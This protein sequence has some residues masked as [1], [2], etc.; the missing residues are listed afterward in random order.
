MFIKFSQLSIMSEASRLSNAST[1]GLS[2]ILICF[3][4]LF[5]GTWTTI[6]AKTVVSMSGTNGTIVEDKDGTHHQS[7][8]L[9]KEPMLLTFV[10]F[11][12]MAFCLVVHVLLEFVKILHTGYNFGTHAGLLEETMSLVSGDG[13]TYIIPE[14]IIIYTSKIPLSTYLTIAIP[15]MLDLGGTLLSFI[16][17]CY[18][19][20]SVSRMLMG[21]GIVFT[22]LMRQHVMKESLHNFQWVGVFWNIVGVFVVGGEALFASQGLGDE[23]GSNGGV[24]FVDSLYG[25]SLVIVG[26]LLLSMDFVSIEAMMKADVSVPPLLLIGMIGLWGVFFSVF[27]MFPIGY[28]LPGDDNG[29]YENLFNTWAILVHSRNIQMVLFIYSVSTFLYT[30]FY[31]LLMFQLGSIWGCILDNFRPITVWAT[32]MLIYY[33]VN[34]KFGESWTAYSY[35]QIAGLVVLLYGTAIFNAP[36]YGGLTLEGQWWAFGINFSEEYYII[37]NQQRQDNLRT[38]DV[39]VTTHSTIVETEEESLGA[40]NGKDLKEPLLTGNGIV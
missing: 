3:F 34:P 30:Y 36:N 17:L 10:M 9:F 14:A 29:S 37:L 27:I 8:E 12:G 19:N 33:F 22:A 4:T 38:D 25:V 40:I 20:A 39:T 7:S 6:S 2:E 11:L 21:S 15:A 23:A 28:A 18:I 32:Q 24:T 5:F 26:S 16:G 1:C 35:L 13:E 31:A